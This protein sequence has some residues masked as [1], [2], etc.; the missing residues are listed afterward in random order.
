MLSWGTLVIWT[1]E[2]VS[3]SF[4]MTRNG[5]NEERRTRRK[6]SCGV[7]PSTSAGTLPVGLGVLARSSVD[8]AAEDTD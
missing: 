7:P 8:V 5:V 2:K 4:R 1:N 6:R 3:G